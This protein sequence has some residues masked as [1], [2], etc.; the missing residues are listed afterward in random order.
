M[1]IIGVLI[2]LG[3]LVVVHEFGHYIAARSF[4]VE[5]EKFSI[6]FGPKLLGY[7]Y[8][9]TNFLISLIPLG[10]YVKM[11]GDEPKD[12]VEFSNKDFYGKKWWQRAV[13]VFAGPI[14]NLLLGLLLF[15]FSFWIG[16]TVEDHK[17]IVGKVSS[18]YE[19]LLLP[20]DQIVA[21]NN[22]DIEYWSQ[23]PEKTRKDDI[24]E[25]VILRD[26]LLIKMVTR[27]IQPTTWYT[28]IQ[29]AVLPI[30]GSVTPGMPAYRAGLQVDD[31]VIAV[32]D[33]EV[34]SWYDM[35]ELIANHQQ[36]TVEL[37]IRREEDTLTIAI[38]LEKNIL[39]DTEQKMI[40]ITQKQP[41]SYFQRFGFFQ[42][43]N[44]GAISTVTFIVVNYYALF[45]LIS[46]PIMAKDQLG[47][48]VMIVA[49]SKQ[50]TALGW[51]AII[52]FVASIS[53]ILMIMNLLPIPILDGGHIFFYFIEGIF[54]KPIPLKTQALIQQIGFMIL[55]ALMIF[56]F[57]NDITRLFRRDLAIKSQQQ[58][59]ENIEIPEN[60][61]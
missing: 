30:V 10:G 22:N 39:F 52:Y 57:Y 14:A 4:G 16:R 2:V 61:Y 59:I 9:G 26:E 41:V 11:S 24:N 54:K 27:D 53:L 55:I 56:V 36:E 23:L 46:R 44:Y 8:K 60:S 28:D 58:T 31:L 7:K 51:G 34:D 12:G 15:T 38:E 49:M 43:I 32:D 3:I 5:V 6:G 29:P 21:L 18:Q 35:R 45:R 19:N 25:V 1:F 50:T 48:P 17:P 42:S 20:Q 33:Q 13:I 37:T 40:G 47:G